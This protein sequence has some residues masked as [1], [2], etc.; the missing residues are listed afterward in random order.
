MTH[1]PARPSPSSRRPAQAVAKLLSVFER[2]AAHPFLVDARTG[3]TVTYAELRSS[4]VRVARHLRSLGVEKG[5]RV[6]L[7]LTN[8]VSFVELF[9]GCVYAGAT[10]VPLHPTFSRFK[11]ADII[12]STRTKVIFASDDLMCPAIMHAGAKAVSVG[13]DGTEAAC[14]ELPRSPAFIPC[15]GVRDD[16]ELAVVFTSGTTSDPKGIAH[17]YADF[18][19]NAAMFSRELGLGPESRFLGLLPMTYLGGHYN[20]LLIPFLCGGSLV[21]VDSFDAKSALRFWRP[22][23]EHGVNTL[24]LVPTIISILMKL[25]RGQEGVRWCRKSRPTVLCG[26]APLPVPLREEFEERYGVALLENYALSET[27]FLTSHLPRARSRPGV[28]TVLPGIELRIGDKHGQ[29]V[30]AGTEG[31]ITVRTPYLTPGYYD[32]VKGELAPLSRK[33]WFATGDLGVLDAAGVLTVTGRKKDLII[34]GGI[35]ISPAAIEETLSRH[36]AVLRCAVVGIPHKLLG[37][38]VAAVVRLSP[39]AKLSE[40]EPRLRAL[41]EESLPP[42]YRPAAYFELPELPQTST[43]KIQKG[44]IRTWLA[45]RTLKG[46]PAAKP[47]HAPHLDGRIDP[48]R[49]FAPSKV[50][51]ESVQAMSIKYNN[52]VYEMQRQ[53]AD[54][55]VLSLGEAF[56]DIP[57]YPFADLPFPKLYHYSH[58]RGIPE[59]REKLAAYFQE[60]YDVSFDPAREIIITAGSKAA[61][62]MSLMSILNPGDETLIHEPAWVSYPEQVKLCYGVPVMVPHDKSVYQFEEYIT[63][64]TKAVIINNPNNPSGKVFSVEEISHLCMLAEKY[65]LF[66]LSD[67]AYSDFLLDGER[68]VSA[69]NI[70]KGLQHTII[71]NSMS[72]NYG[73]SGWRIGY[74]ITNP[75]LTD[76][77]L[78]VNQHL[79]TCPATILEYYLAKHFDDIIRITKPQILDLVRRRAEI[80][81]RMDA[82]GLKCL[83]GT[84]TFYFFVSTAPSTLSS[85]EFCT[86]LLEK[87]HVCAVPGLGYG[88]SCDR[89]IRVSV[90]AESVERIH[91]G[92]DR[93]KALIDAT[94]G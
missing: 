65:N 11:A 37:E 54:V 16:D 55:T 19:G 13:K 40:V 94:R 45:E 50:V 60:Q 39:E 35:N 22:V 2:R 76:Q 27:L 69:G 18:V 14:P 90:G 1:R 28:G 83:P 88:K 64:R 87:D 29:N 23:I 4:A 25:D 21:V 6:A 24:W 63:N 81:R 77:I 10:A 82:I 38:D 3:R 31:E 52:K 9:F 92:L 84:A 12:R 93:I 61:I 43:G 5:D 17:T 72:K 91:R 70:D 62:H 33:D 86:R 7:S 75:A 46:T 71:C 15:Q 66:I 30:P 59:L 79:V 58:S 8:S 53:G 26:T 68:F 36:P 56:F 85:E 42:I 41:C 78:K 80:A 51:A 20:L 49:F 32:T 74:C 44:K 89:F 34:R 47:P 73:M 67:E 57:L 48:A